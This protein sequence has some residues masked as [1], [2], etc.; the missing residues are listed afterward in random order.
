MIL[1][2]IRHGESEADILDVHE[3]RADFPLTE[4]G[5][6]QAEKMAECVS[7]EFRVQKIYASTL[8]RAM[9]TAA[10]LSEACG[11]SLE[12]EEGLMEFDNGLIAGLDRET[13]K[14]KYPFVPF[15][16]LHASV[17]E[18]ESQ[19]QFRFRAEVMLSRILTENGKDDTIAAVSHGG[20]I[21]QLLRAFLRLPVDSD[22]FFSTGDTGIH[23]LKIDETGRRIAALNRLSH[24]G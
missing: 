23:I 9:Q 1:L 14:R 10:C 12:P 24:I 3:G 7:K 6:L 21:N 13:V 8:K 15:L 22:V 20:M 19:M 18:Q 5:R 2:L 17:Y 11:I 4:R 16:P